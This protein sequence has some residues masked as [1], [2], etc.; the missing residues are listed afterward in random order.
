MLTPLK[1]AVG[2]WRGKK[3]EGED[4]EEVPGKQF[5]AGERR[6]PPK[7]V[8]ATLGKV[9]GNRFAEADS[10]KMGQGRVGDSCLQ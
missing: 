5:G 6:N 1:W 4:L 10:D 9:S 2:K 7:E 3:W 8:I